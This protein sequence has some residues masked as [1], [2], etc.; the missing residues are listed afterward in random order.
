M[1][2]QID[3]D[4]SSFAWYDLHVRQTV[5]FLVTANF[6]GVTEAQVVCVAPDQVVE[7]GREPAQ[8]SGAAC[9]WPNSIWTMIAAFVVNGVVNRYL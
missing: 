1:E 3:T 5:P 2:E 8:R 4:L 9:G 7:G 6:G